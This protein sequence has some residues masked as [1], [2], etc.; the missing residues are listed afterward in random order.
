MSKDYSIDIVNKALDLLSLF[1]YRRSTLTL[2][3]MTSMLGQ[4]RSTV[5][6]IVQTLLNRDF[7]SVDDARRRYSLGPAAAQLGLIARTTGLVH[8]FIQKSMYELW[9]EFRETVNYALLQEDTLLYCQI[10][11]SPHAFRIS[12]NVGDVVPFTTTAMGRAVLAA[13]EHPERL[14]S[15]GELH[16]IAGKL[17]KARELGYSVD[18]EETERGVR[19][20]GVALRD[21]AGNVFGAISVSGPSTRLTPDQVPDIGKRLVS[22]AHQIIELTRP[23]HA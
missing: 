4:P 16:L 9:N 8:Q 1:D 7:L 19:C 11:D 13:V 22:V 20:V 15:P 12:E 14:V 21:A 17:A 3:E 5:Y 10:L 6:R 18:D 2:D 23:N